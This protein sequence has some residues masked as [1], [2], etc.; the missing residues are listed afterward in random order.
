MEMR[1]KQMICW[2]EANV[3]NGSG[4]DVDNV[5]RNLDGKESYFVKRAVECSWLLM[6]IVDIV[7]L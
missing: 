2:Y 3:G 6:G 1:D 7:S 4:A 5:G